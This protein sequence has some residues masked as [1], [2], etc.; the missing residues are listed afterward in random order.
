M[1]AIELMHDNYHYTK[2]NTDET[3]N[4]V[5]QLQ[6]VLRQAV[7]FGECLLLRSQINI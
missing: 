2:E 7:F 6:Y 1:S 4:C 3:W 5:V